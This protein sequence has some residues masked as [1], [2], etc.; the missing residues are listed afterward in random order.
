LTIIKEKKNLYA[1]GPF[2]ENFGPE[3]S[4]NDSFFG[5]H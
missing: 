2:S 4:T 1:E 3:A 5:Y